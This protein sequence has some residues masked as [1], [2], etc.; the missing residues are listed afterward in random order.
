MA[1][2]GVNV[3]RWSALGLGLFYGVYHQ[4]QISTKEKL[5]QSKREYAHKEDLIKKAKA[6]YAQKNAPASSKSDIITDP[7]H[8]N[9]D[10][11]KFLKAKAGN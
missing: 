3:L 11:E 6:E 1:S 7:E 5:D 9:F 2:T 8:P 10:L 4:A